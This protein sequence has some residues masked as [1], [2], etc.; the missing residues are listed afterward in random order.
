MN[1]AD[2]D[3]DDDDEDEHGNGDE[4]DE[5]KEAEEEAEELQ[6]KSDDATAC[7][8]SLRAGMYG[9]LA[10]LRAHP[11]SGLFWE[12]VDETQFPDYSEY[13]SKPMDLGTVTSRVSLELLP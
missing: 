8:D 1:Y 12:P 2:D 6:T 11:Q 13:V 9:A 4:G 10:N 5:S 7:G 3:D